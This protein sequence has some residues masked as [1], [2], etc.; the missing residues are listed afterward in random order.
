[1]LLPKIA[2][3]TYPLKGEKGIELIKNA[4]EVGFR[5]LDSAD[6]YKNHKE[7]SQAIKLS[8]LKREDVIICTKVWRENLN[9]KQVILDV[10]DFL[11]ELNTKYI[12]VLLIHWPNKN[13]PLNKTLASF[14]K[15]KQIGVI[16]HFGV[17][18]FDIPHLQKALQI[19]TEIEFNQIEIHPSLKQVELYEFCNK[20]GIKIMSHSSLAKGI[21]LELPLIQSIA[22]KYNATPAQIIYCY[23]II[24]GIIPVVSGNNV[25]IIK[26]NF[27][28]LKLNLSS[29]DVQLLDNLNTAQFRSLDKEYSEF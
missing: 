3:G 12:D 7:I 24:K 29:D 20:N 28:A 14:K 1:M 16:K 10:K 11:K 5:M 27:L 17:S 26:E 13:I 15:L 2:Y 6:H 19:T 9:E 25:K 22:K 23:L 18:N 8:N 4:L 21:N